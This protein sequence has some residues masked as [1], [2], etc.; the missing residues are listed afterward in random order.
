MSKAREHVLIRS[1]TAVAVLPTG[2]RVAGVVLDRRTLV[3][4]FI[5]IASLTGTIGPAVMLLTPE[6]VGS[7]AASDCALTEPERTAVR[8]I[9]TLAVRLPCCASAFLSHA[10]MIAN[11]RSLFR[12]RMRRVRLPISTGEE[13]GGK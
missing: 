12:A 2:F 7:A 10:F 5:G 13:R 9:L 3:K 8:D 11:F 6:T 1:L 4:I